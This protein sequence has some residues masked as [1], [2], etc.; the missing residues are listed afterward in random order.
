MKIEVIKVLEHL[1]LSYVYQYSNY[2]GKVA[3]EQV[4]IEISKG[5]RHIEVLRF[6]VELWWLSCGAFPLGFLVLI[7]KTK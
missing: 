3:K 5:L 2:W 6:L 1:F 7:L 4:I